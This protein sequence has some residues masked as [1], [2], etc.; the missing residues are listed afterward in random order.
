G[1]Y[2]GVVAGRVAGTR[3]QLG[4]QVS[5]QLRRVLRVVK[6]TAIDGVTEHGEAHFLAVHHGALEIL[7][8]HDTGGG[9]KRRAED[10]AGEEH[11]RRVPV[12]LEGG[13]HAERQE[14]G[15]VVLARR[16]RYVGVHRERRVH[17]LDR[18]AAV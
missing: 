2:A 14:R 4:R 16:I 8:A 18:I 10:R 13:S 17:L 11:R 1:R 12:A 5:P 6:L 3:I 15:R 9:H 7:D